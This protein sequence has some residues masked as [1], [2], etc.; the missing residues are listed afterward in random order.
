[1]DSLRVPNVSANS[2]AGMFSQTVLNVP[3]RFLA[4]WVVNSHKTE[5]RSIGPMSACLLKKRVRSFVSEIA[6]RQFWLL[7]FVVFTSAGCKALKV[8]PPTDRIRPSNFREWSPD[9]S[10]TSTLERD[11]NRITVRNIRDNEYL[12]ERD[13]IV[14]YH[15]KSFDL[16]QIRSVDFVVVPFDNAPLLAHTMLSFGLSD[17]TYLTMSVEIRT[18]KGEEYSPVLGFVRQYE[19]VYVIAT[20]RDLIRLRT[21]HR[22]ARVYVFPTIAT[23]QQSQELFLDVMNRANQLAEHP[24]F[25]NTIRNNCTT[26]LVSHVNGIK[27][28][29]V[30]YA[31][32]VLFPGHSDRY[33]YD[34]GLLGRSKPF[35]QLKKECL[36]NDLAEKHYDAPDFSTKI[37]ERISQLNIR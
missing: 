4:M 27:N 6:L 20:E 37:R 11:G 10:L 13:F 28:N 30:P 9:F 25:Y 36:I 19:L 15:D 16:D 22:D 35:D 8:N 14:N 17:G 32:Q 3:N 31:W 34:L 29:A 24:E 26:N 7:L 23:A 1:M 33:A 21:R 2:T 12:S 5:I 18:E